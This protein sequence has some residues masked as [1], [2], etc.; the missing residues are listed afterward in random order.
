VTTVQPSVGG[1]LPVG[2]LTV[3]AAL[4]DLDG[5][6][7]DS[8]PVWSVAEAEIMTWLGG[9]WNAGVKAA[10]LGRPI[11]VSCRELVRIAGSSIG[12]AVVQSRLLA[13]MV[14]L[15]RADLPWQ[16]GARELLSALSARGVPLALVSSSYRVLVDAALETIGGHWFATTVAGDEVE[17][18]KPHPEPYLTAA[19]RLGIE[20]SACV[21]FEDSP[22]GLAAGEAAGCYCVVVPDVVPVADRPGRMVL[23]SLAGLEIESPSAP[24]SDADV[25]LPG[26]QLGVRAAPPCRERHR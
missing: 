7:V 21:V 5:L 23:P 16:P 1:P 15:F 8:E 17:H 24:E 20:P 14:D 9:P 19:R 2:R 22:T 12:P 11:E 26:F 3:R 10:C 13:R 6:L 18:G 25:G 4:F